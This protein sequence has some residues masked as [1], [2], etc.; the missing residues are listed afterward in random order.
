MKSGLHIGMDNLSPRSTG[1][2]GV[3]HRLSVHIFTVRF[4]ERSPRQY[5]Q[6]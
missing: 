4:S 3:L 5:F 1:P 2:L 6:P